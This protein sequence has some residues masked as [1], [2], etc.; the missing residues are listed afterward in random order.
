MHAF[1][2]RLLVAV[3]DE[4]VGARLVPDDDAFWADIPVAE[5]D[6]TFCFRRQRVADAADLE[7]LI[8]LLRARP[9]SERVLVVSDRLVERV[10]TG[11][12]VAT[13][14]ARR[15]RESL[16]TSSHLSGLLAVT[17]HSSGARVTDI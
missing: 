16:R 8:A 1:P 5:H 2:I 9:T 4:T 3:S 13:A 14:L 10:D 11:A 6:E 15:V 17:D 12:L 7:R